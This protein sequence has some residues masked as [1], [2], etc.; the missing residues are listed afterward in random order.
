MRN[1]RERL[2]S[3]GVARTGVLVRVVDNDDHDL[4][5]GEIGEVMVRSDCVMDGY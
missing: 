5:P 1:W 3:C 2:G 4:P